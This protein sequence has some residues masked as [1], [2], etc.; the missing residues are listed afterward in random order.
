MFAAAVGEGASGLAFEVDEEEVGGGFGLGA[1][2]LAEVVVA[3]DANSL[4]EAGGV[5]VEGGD[6][7]EEVVAVGE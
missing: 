6:A 4:A 3:V 5:A 1:E 2:E 7:G